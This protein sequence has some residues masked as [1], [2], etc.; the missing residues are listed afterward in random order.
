MK[1]V[2]QGA[3]ELMGWALCAVLALV[4]W[5]GGSDEMVKL[6]FAGE[7]GRALMWPDRAGAAEARAQEMQISMG[8]RI[9]IWRMEMG[10][11]HLADGMLGP[12]AMHASSQVEAAG[13]LVVADLAHDGARPGLGPSERPIELSYAGN[14]GAEGMTRC[15]GRR[16]E[17]Y[18]K[19]RG[20]LLHGWSVEQSIIS[21]GSVILGDLGSSDFRLLGY[22]EVRLLRGKLKSRW[23][24]PYTVVKA[25]DNGVVII[26]DQKTGYSFTVN[27]QRSSG[28]FRRQS[29]GAELMRWAIPAEA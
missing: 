4:C 7:G 18:I 20:P 16:R 24:G 8:G 23:D 19:T 5:S 9:S 21:S 15:R 1:L 12:G 29:S 17:P 14:P 2:K 27:G 11:L 10:V 22:W 28:N 13:A 25:Y 6:G 3:E 26:L